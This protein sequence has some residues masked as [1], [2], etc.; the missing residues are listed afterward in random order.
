MRA[1]EGGGGA[2]GEGGERVGGCEEEGRA[3][4]VVCVDVGGW[5]R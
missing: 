5:G 1:V 2:A 3:E 4:A